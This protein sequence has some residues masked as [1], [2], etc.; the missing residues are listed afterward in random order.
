M[1]APAG[2]AVFIIRLIALAKIFMNLDGCRGFASRLDD[3]VFQRVFSGCDSA[4]RCRD[5]FVDLPNLF[6]KMNDFVEVL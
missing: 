6:N 5:L 2:R 4:G 3:G 1:N